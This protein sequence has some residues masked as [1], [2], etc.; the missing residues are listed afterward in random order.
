MNVPLTEAAAN[1]VRRTPS[2]SHIPSHLDHRSDAILGQIR[3]P[4]ED[5][6]SEHATSASFC[7]S[8]VSIT[9]PLGLR[10]LVTIAQIRCRLCTATHLGIP[11]VRS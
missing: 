7:T 3:H 1:V 10:N 4:R 2:G 9:L 5:V 6:V 8:I 11:P